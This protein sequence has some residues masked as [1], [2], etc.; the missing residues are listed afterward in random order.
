[1]NGLRLGSKEKQKNS[2][3]FENEFLDYE[4]KGEA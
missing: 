4:G 2:F 1:M 3:V